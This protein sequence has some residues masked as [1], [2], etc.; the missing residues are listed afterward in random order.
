MHIKTERQKQRERDT[1]RVNERPPLPGP[2]NPFQMILPGLYGSTDPQRTCHTNESCVSASDRRPCCVILGE[3]PHLSGDTESLHPSGQLGDFSNH[4][5][6]EGQLRAWLTPWLHCSK[7]G[8]IMTISSYHHAEPREG[9]GRALHL[10]AFL[11]WA[12][13]VWW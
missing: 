1:E 8:P 2:G 6:A 13:T 4:K 7:L 12:D 3:S 9:V 11:S 5:H 10:Q